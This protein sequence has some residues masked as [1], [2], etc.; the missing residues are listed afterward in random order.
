MRQTAQELES[1]LLASDDAN[2]LLENYLN[3]V[4]KGLMSSMNGRL[5]FHSKNAQKI[6]I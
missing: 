2:Q 5:V 6:R 3:P 4:M 1:V